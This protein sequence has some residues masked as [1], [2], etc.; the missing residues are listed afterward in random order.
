MVFKAVFA[1]TVL[2][3][4]GA[5]ALV[6]GRFLGLIDDSPETVVDACESLTSAQR[7]SLLGTKTP[8]VASQPSR[9]AVRTTC[10]WTATEGDD[11]TLVAVTSM[12]AG[13]WVVELA[14]DRASSGTDGPVDAARRDVMQR[15]LELGTGA[16]DREA[17]ALASKVFELDGAPSGAQLS[18]TFEAGRGKSSPRLVAEGCSAG[19]FTRIVAAAPDLRASEPLER[20]ATQVLEQVQERLS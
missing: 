11:A 6:G 19:T 12:S 5:S 10:R 14:R 1:L 13:A 2:L 4:L 20:R 9:G 8:Y 3:V 17:C 16:S 15:A 7:K 18:V